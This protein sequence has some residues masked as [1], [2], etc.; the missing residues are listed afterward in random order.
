MVD[1]APGSLDAMDDREEIEE[2]LRD[3]WVVPPVDS[4]AR[5]R[6]MADKCSTCVF[7]PGNKMDLVAGRVK[8]MVESVRATDSY[9]PCHKTL[10]T[11]IPSAICRGGHEAHEGALARMADRLGGLVEVTEAEIVIELANRRTRP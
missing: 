1:H 4:R 2:Q 11:G 9:I 8:Q 10:G 3:G 5:I 7:R 6:L